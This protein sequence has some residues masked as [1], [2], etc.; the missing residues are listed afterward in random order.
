VKARW[1]SEDPAP[2][3]PGI[4]R[5]VVASWIPGR[6]HLISTIESDGRSLE[7][8]FTEALQSGKN[9][10]EVERGRQ[11]FKTQIVRCDKHGDHKPDAWFT[12]LYEREY[13]TREE[14]RRGHKTI[15]AL[16]AAGKPL[17]PA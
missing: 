2:N 11:F 6:F 1:V 7:A 5:A 3:L 15:V 8:R 13:Q 10:E 4:G 9:L 16:F 14:A 12:P 17:P